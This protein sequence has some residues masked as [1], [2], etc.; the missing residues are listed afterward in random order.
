MKYQIY[1][2]IPFLFACSE[3][4]LSSKVGESSYD[5][6]EAEAPEDYYDEDMRS[7]LQSPTVGAEADD[8][9]G[10]ETESDFMS[11][12]PATTNVFVFVAN[13]DRNTVTR[14]KV[15]ELEVMTAE[16][17]VE[18]LLVETSSDYTRAVTFNKGSD[19]ISIM[20]Q[21]H[22]RSLMSPF[23]AISIR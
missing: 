10:S 16:V 4:A 15:P 23:E 17:G 8:G 22:C 13:P 21:R 9:F 6:A 3:M 7:L 14:I 11:L 19:D 20:T 18:P 1:L 12:R 2:S 5:S